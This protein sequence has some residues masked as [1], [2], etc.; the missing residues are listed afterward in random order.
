MAERLVR[1]TSTFLD[2]HTSRRGFLMRAVITGTAMAVAPIRYLTRP[3]SAWACAGVGTCPPGC[4]GGNACCDGY[5]EFCISNTGSNCCPA[6]TFPAG[7]WKAC[8]SYC[9]QNYTGPCGQS[10]YSGPG[11][12]NGAARYY[13]DCARDLGHT[14]N[15]TGGSCVCNA[16]TCSCRIM[17][18]NQFTYCNM[19]ISDGQ[20]TCSNIGGDNCTSGQQV[21]CRV[22]VC[23][24]PC[25]LGPICGCSGQPSGTCP[26]GS[27]SCTGIHDCCTCYHQP[28]TGW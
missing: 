12:C 1:S 11:P 7:W 19:N 21:V 20:Q 27:K 26:N 3:E 17:C 23:S 10:P 6:W 24:N 18:C 5:T 9:A 13:V 2:R 14:C 4:S 8:D 22:V 25:G 16:G 15:A 28:C